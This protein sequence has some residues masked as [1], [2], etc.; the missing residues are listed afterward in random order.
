MAFLTENAVSTAFT[1]RER[2]V[3][4]QVALELMPGVDVLAQRWA[5]AIRLDAPVEKI[6]QMRRTLAGMTSEILRGFFQRLAE[7][8]PEG[9]LS[10]YERFIY[11][12]IHSQL[13][14]PERQRA[15]IEVLFSSAEPIRTLL[16]REIERILGA[17]ERRAT[18]VLLCFSRL[19]SVAAE[20]LGQTYSHL[21]EAHLRR[22]YDEAQ[23]TAEH[24]RESEERFRLLVGELKRTRDA[25]LE[26]SRLKSAF[27]ANM[28][29]EIHTPLNIILGY[30]D[31]MAE[32]LNELGDEERARDFGD[33]VRRAG[34]R[35]LGTI[36]A[37]LEIS[38]MEAGGYKLA[39]RDINLAEFTVRLL[40]EFKVLAERKGL[41]LSARVDAP[42][43][44]VRCDENC[45]SNALTN[46]L[47]NA[48]K[49]T[50]SGAVTVRVYRDGDQA[51]CL[52]IADSG[53]GIDPAYLPHI[54]EPFSQ[55]NNNPARR[56]EGVGLGLA[57]V[58]KYLEL[59]GAR[60][61]VASEKGKGS[62]FTI[63]F[64]GSALPQP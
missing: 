33:P 31:L 19:W 21:R 51:E 41:A 25:A 58:R 8:D 30:V 29:H 6:P 53:I 36:N 47:Q 50:E 23:R 14:E 43:A 28:T 2:D 55:E 42:D 17:E 49:F 10:V 16:V 4:A 52:E 44:V 15:T 48:I 40:G 64:R 20:L 32:R 60:I 11:G 35:L 62:T 45:L 18:Y 3:M 39:P 56:F 57:L 37:I 5:E 27:L 13:D 59:N 9:A 22:L 46:L 38:K 1:D 61:A 26:S 24:L 12:L 54:F 34:T 7:G 63:R